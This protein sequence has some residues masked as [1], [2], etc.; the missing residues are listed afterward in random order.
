MAYPSEPAFECGNGIIRSDTKL[1]EGVVSCPKVINLALDRIETHPRLPSLPLLDQSSRASVD[2]CFPQGLP[3]FKTLVH[4]ASPPSLGSTTVFFL[5]LHSSKRFPN[6]PHVS[7]SSG[8]RR[9][10]WIKP[11]RLLSAPADSLRNRVVC[12][13]TSSLRVHS[14][15]AAR[16][17]EQQGAHSGTVTPL[18]QQVGSLPPSMHTSSLCVVQK[19]LSQPVTSRRCP[20]CRNPMS[21]ST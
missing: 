21:L 11:T 16:R 15:S 2:P 3:V 14:C 6:L 20:V 19:S 8:R 10:H 18:A 12:L 5:T 4:L 17:C 7:L 1:S 9:W 13:G